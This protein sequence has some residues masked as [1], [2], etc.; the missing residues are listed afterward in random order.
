MLP[1]AARRLALVLL[2]LPALAA[3]AQ[4]SPRVLVLGDSLSAAYGIELLDPFAFQTDNK[5][6]LALPPLRGR[7]REHPRLNSNDERGSEEN[8]QPWNAQETR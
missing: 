1:T 4:A 7:V 5:N 3:G 2:L 6:H 8:R